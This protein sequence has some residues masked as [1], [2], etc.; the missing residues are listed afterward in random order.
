MRRIWLAIRVFFLVLF[1]A[2]VARRMAQ[3]TRQGNGRRKLAARPAP[4][5]AKSMPVAKKSPGRSEAITLLATLQRE[6]R[7]V[8][9]I[10]EPLANFSDANG[11][12]ARDVH[13][14]C[15]KVLQRLFEL[16]P[17]LSDEEGATVEV[18]AG[19]EAQ[20]DRLTG[21]VAGD[22]PF[23]GRL[24]HHGW[25]ADVCQLP[26]WSGRRKRHASWPPRKLRWE[27]LGLRSWVLGL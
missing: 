5:V 22:P 13:R 4:T 1:H 25:E 8:D 16:R 14:E 7:F 3:G 6:A 27:D 17:V 21:D 19:F 2:G 15:G 11:A 18:P 9:F 12:A 24:V 26:A 10:Q 20:R 23:R